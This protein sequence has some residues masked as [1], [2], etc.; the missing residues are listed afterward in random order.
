MLLT[1]G[2]PNAVVVIV[3][4]RLVVVTM[5]ANKWSSQGCYAVVAVLL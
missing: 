3:V 5:A 4:L 2:V 1:N